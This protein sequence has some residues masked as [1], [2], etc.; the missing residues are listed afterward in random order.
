M[1]RRKIILLVED[2]P[3]IALNETFVL[4]REGYTVIAAGDGLQAVGRP[5]P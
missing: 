4:E 5:P 2:E 1:N 3:L